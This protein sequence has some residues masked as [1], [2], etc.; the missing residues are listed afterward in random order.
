MICLLCVAP[1][2]L[3]SLPS[4]SIH[5]P[6]LLTAFRSSAAQP[7]RLL[8]GKRS[9]GQLPPASRN[10][11]AALTNAIVHDRFKLE[12]RNHVLAILAERTRSPRLA[13]LSLWIMAYATGPDDVPRTLGDQLGSGAGGSDRLRTEQA[14]P[15][16]S[17]HT[18]NYSL[19]KADMSQNRQP[20]AS[21]KRKQRDDGPLAVFC[22]WVVDHQIGTMLPS[23]C[24]ISSNG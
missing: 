14:H 1:P 18:E 11:H 12:P 9:H 24:Y 6:A 7:S 5:L 22:A 10:K 13:S 20:S 16:S 15:S 4:E 21:V 8:A 17:S 19:G 2:S 23:S 3:P